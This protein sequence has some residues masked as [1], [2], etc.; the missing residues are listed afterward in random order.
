MGVVSGGF[1]STDYG[2]Y[3]FVAHHQ[4]LN[5]I[6]CQMALTSECPDDLEDDAV[7]ADG[8]AG[9]N[10]EAESEK[11][12]GAA[13]DNDEDYPDILMVKSS[14][15]AAESHW[16]RMGVY[17]KM[18][19]ITRNERPVWKMRGGSDIYIYFD[20]KYEWGRRYLSR[21][22]HYNPV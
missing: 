22:L 4:V 8:S 5:W 17:K 9:E 3:V 21:Y 18:G 10:E 20:G 1:R 14:G 11:D 2:Y 6:K 12:N 16:G 13:R 7:G 19:G 15:A